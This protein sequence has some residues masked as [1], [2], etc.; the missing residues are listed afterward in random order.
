MDTLKPYA[1]GYAFNIDGTYIR[2]CN[3]NYNFKLR[4]VC[5]EN[6][7]KP[8]WKIIDDTTIM[9]GEGVLYKIIAINQDSMVLQHLKCPHDPFFKLHRDNDQTT[10]PKAIIYWDT[11]APIGM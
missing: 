1:M 9:F 7:A 2:Y 11:L 10:K 3:P 5:N 6:T 8:I 4:A